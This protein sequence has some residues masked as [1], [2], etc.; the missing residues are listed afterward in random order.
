M[1]NLF[2]FINSFQD[3]PNEDIKE[4]T[5]NLEAALTITTIRQDAEGKIATEK[6]KHVY[7]YMLAEKLEAPKNFPSTQK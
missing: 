3:I 1:Q 4:H 5:S 6:N 7:G 2:G